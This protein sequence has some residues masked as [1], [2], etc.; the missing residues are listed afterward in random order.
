MVKTLILTSR[1][2]VANTSNSVFQYDF[3]LGGVTFKD[4]FIAVQ[5]ISLYNSVFNISSANN[6]NTFSYTW[7]D[8]S[9]VNITIPDSY[10]SLEGINQFLQSIM[11]NNKHYL[12]TTTGDNVYLLELVVNPSKYAY[13]LNSYVIS[14][15][16]ATTNSWSLPAGATWVLPTNLICPIFT[17]PNTQFKSLIG[18]SAGNYPNA[19]I[20]GTPPAQTQSPAYTSAQSFLSTTA[21]Q[22]IVQPNFLCICSLVNNRF[23]IPSQLLTTITPVG[24]G[25]GELFVQQFNDLAYNRIENGVY[26]NFTFRFVDTLGNPIQFQDPNIVILLN[27]KNRDE[28]L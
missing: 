25:F 19:T 27:I 3:P 13:Q 8:G 16:L 14:A 12:T 21:P 20:S 22:I 5:Q 26:N 1:N 15:T 23:A 11:I 7:V 18:Y 9:V 4:D 10:L 2:I 6:N 24:V 28:V 17:V